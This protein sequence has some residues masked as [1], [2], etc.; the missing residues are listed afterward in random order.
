L[1]QAFFNP[2]M[3]QIPFDELLPIVTSRSRLFRHI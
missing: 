3:L 1:R 2:D